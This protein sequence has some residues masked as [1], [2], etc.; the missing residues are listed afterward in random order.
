M[1]SWLRKTS[2]ALWIAF[3]ATFLIPV[4]FL[5]MFTVLAAKL[6]EAAK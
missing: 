2:L 4:G 3:E 1:G 5:G 6:R